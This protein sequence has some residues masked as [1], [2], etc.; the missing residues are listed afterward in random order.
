MVKNEIEPQNCRIVKAGKDL[1]DYCYVNN[2]KP[3]K[4][5]TKPCS[6]FIWQRR[7]KT[8]SELLRTKAI[9]V[10]IFPFFLCMLAYVCMFKKMENLNRKKITGESR[11]GYKKVWLSNNRILKKAKDL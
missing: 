8:S 6:P 2:Q 10:Q 9:I 11:Q 4:Y 3:A 5:I 1:W 7:K